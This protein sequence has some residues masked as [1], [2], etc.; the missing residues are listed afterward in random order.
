MASSPRWRWLAAYKTPVWLGALFIALL[1]VFA[2]TPDPTS[3]DV[4]AVQA[5]TEPSPGPRECVVCPIDQRCDAKSGRCVFIDHTPLP[6]VPSAKF[7]DKAG[8]CLPEG[9]PPAPAPV[10]SSEDDRARRVD[11]GGVRVP[12]GN[13]Q[14]RLPGFG[15]DDD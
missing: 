4:D 12:R 14:P 11:D 2:I 3:G 5:T 1:A 15:N 10:V 7:D 8:F 9:A 13:R 6:C